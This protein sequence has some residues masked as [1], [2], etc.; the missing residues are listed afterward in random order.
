MTDLAQTDVRLTLAGLRD[1]LL[2]ARGQLLGMVDGTGVDGSQD[3]IA[4][5]NGSAVAE[6]QAEAELTRLQR[7]SLA[8]INA[9]LDRFDDGSFGTCLGCGHAIPV[10]R[11]EVMP[12][13]SRCLECQY[14]REAGSAHDDLV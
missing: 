10:E 3:E 5:R 7:R 11:L 9:A 2:Q 4:E 13:A 14:Q 6:R 12:S 8:Q 1:E